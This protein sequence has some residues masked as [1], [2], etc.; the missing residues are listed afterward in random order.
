M[1]FEDYPIEI[2]PLPKDEGGGYL[3]TVPD[4]PGCI[5]DGD[6]IES[7]V[8]E[9]RDAF[10]AWTRAE[11]ED[12]GA[13][14]A[15]GATYEKL[16][17]K[18]GAYETAR[19]EALDLAL[20]YGPTQA[21]SEQALSHAGGRK[22]RAAAESRRAGSV[23]GE[24]GSATGEASEVRIRTGMD[25][26]D[27]SDLRRL[28]DL[29]DQRNA[30]ERAIAELIGRPGQPGHVGEFIAARIFDIDLE[31]SA[32]QPGY[33]GR[34]GSGPLA[35]KSVDVKYYSKWET[36]LDVNIKHVP[37][38]YLV[39][40]GP[41]STA[42]NSRG[43]SRSWAVDNVFLFEAKPLIDRLRERGVKIGTAT[44]VRNDEWE[45]ARIYPVGADKSPVTIT[46]TQQEQIGMFGSA[47]IS[48][49]T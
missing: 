15:P 47:I 5:A 37:D 41:K 12:T 14:P 36:M 2:A 43:T 7:A 9:A 24:N 8:A 10:E 29:L 39:L 26:K 32:N 17:R 33:D 16:S 18:E 3:V 22:R 31:P 42:A 34:F 49:T 28:A 6:T 44:S 35:Q 21:E 48:W 11:R 30:N 23:H 1:K 38:Y 25:M 27:D 46:K 40:A 20:T 19:S 4:L 13:L 45:R